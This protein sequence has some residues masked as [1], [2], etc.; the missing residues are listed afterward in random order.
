M[1]CT[2]DTRR[3]FIH[4]GVSIPLRTSHDA[5]HAAHR[6]ASDRVTH[7]HSGERVRV[8]RLA[9]HD[10][11]LLPLLFELLQNLWN[12]GRWSRS[13][14]RNWAPDVTLSSL[15][16]RL[17]MLKLGQLSHKLRVPKSKKLLQ[18]SYNSITAQTHLPQFTKNLI[19]K[20]Q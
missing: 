4:G 11:G 5:W 13:C 17:I 16:H 6:V 12:I 19:N 3:H 18:L 9:L 7:A 14:D 10:A 15:Q 20:N 1:L 2:M 8:G